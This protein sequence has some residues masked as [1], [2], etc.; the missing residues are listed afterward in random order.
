MV[1]NG[2]VLLVFYQYRQAHVI[3]SAATEIATVANRIAGPVA[4]Y[5]ATDELGPARDLL[6]VFAAFPYII[7]ADFGIG[8]DPPMVSW[9]ALGCVRIKRAGEDVWIDVPAAAGPAY[10]MVR[11]DPATVLADL[12]REFLIL[13]GLAFIGG[14]AIIL[15]A[16]A[17][18]RWTINRPLTHMLTAIERFE[19]HDR[20]ARVD[21][22]SEDEI[23]QV[24][25]SYNAMLDR[26]VERLAEIRKAHNAIVESVS[27]ASRIQR[28]LLPPNEH[29]VASFADVAVLWQPRDVVGGDIYWVA[30]A[31]PR[32]TLAL[33][34]C[35]GHG[36]PGGFMTM[37]AVATL[38][39]VFG[40]SE[41]P[42]TGRSSRPAQPADPQ[43]AQPGHR[44]AGLERRYGCGRLPDRRRQPDRDLCRRASVAAGRAGR[45]GDL[46]ARRPGERRLPRF[47][48]RVAAPG[49]PGT[50]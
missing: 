23:G 35:T 7:C 11:Y 29:L 14:L 22:R 12:H 49:G 41:D 18:F 27:Y 9:P 38:E 42:R 39:R 25:R 19:H 6:G 31:G 21:H 16:V 47:P 24:V 36:V 37:I 1:A 44:R 4:G 8:D 26:E 5:L 48:S 28:G 15:P 17:A 33:L 45:S 13:L 50:A 3:G 43:P 34:D 40:E 10:L 32:T 30:E 20:T 46:R 2:V